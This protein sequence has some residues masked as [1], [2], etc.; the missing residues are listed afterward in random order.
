MEDPHDWAVNQTQRCN[1]ASM[2][3]PKASLA[4]HLRP[5]IIQAFLICADLRLVPGVCQLSGQEEDG[6]DEEAIKFMHFCPVLH[7]MLAKLFCDIRFWQRR[8]SGSCNKLDAS[9]HYI[10]SVVIMTKL[11]MNVSDYNEMR[12]KWQHHLWMTETA[13]YAKEYSWV[14]FWLCSEELVQHYGDLLLVPLEKNKTKQKKNF[15]A[16]NI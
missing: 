11:S 10:R 5:F 14:L 12:S 9:S 4:T 6:S 16:S 15:R 13:V 8:F 1:I 2:T 7:Q 3:P